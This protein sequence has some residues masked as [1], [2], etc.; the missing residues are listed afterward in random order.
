MKPLLSFFLSLLFLLAIGSTEKTAG[1]MN[2]DS[3]AVL[4]LELGGDHAT[5]LDYEPSNFDPSPDL[6]EGYMIGHLGKMELQEHERIQ[7]DSKVSSRSSRRKLRKP[8]NRR[9]IVHKAYG[10]PST[11]SMPRG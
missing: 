11:R 1:A 7:R 10:P 4:S 8:F 2:P 3:D 9:S 6:S 5:E